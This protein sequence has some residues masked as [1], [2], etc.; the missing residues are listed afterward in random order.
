MVDLERKNH[1]NLRIN[2]ISELNEWAKKNTDFDK[3]SAYEAVKFFDSDKENI[4]KDLEIVNKIYFEIN[5]HAKTQ[6][7]IG[8]YT[9][10]EFANVI[11]LK[12][13]EGE[14][15]EKIREQIKSANSSLI[16]PPLTLS[17]KISK[18]QN[19]VLKLT[20]GLTEKEISQSKLIEKLIEL[21][22][23]N[24]KEAEEYI[25]KSIKIGALTLS[26]SEN[27]SL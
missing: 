16:N 1:A 23:F 8:K 20:E 4:S 24:E 13:T 7:K 21:G 11:L 19:T 22:E 25:N 12:K 5:N 6:F 2:Q 10:M 27:I 14:N 3:I 15:I 18:I 26:D 17:A 9:A